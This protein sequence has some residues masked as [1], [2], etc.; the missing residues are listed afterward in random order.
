MLTRKRA[1]SSQSIATRSS[2]QVSKSGRKPLPGTGCTK[3]AEPFVKPH[4]PKRVKAED[5]I[6]D[7][8][9]LGLVLE[10][11]PWSDFLDHD[12]F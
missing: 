12:D 3:S 4:R 5:P 1:A 10:K 8:E 11:I 9:D 7:I 2:T 6:P